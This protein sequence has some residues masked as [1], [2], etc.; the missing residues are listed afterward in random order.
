MERDPVAELREKIAKD[1]SALAR[2]FLGNWQA[3][4]LRADSVP[5]NMGAVESY[6]A[7]IALDPNN[8]PALA[9]LRRITQ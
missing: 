6:R 3:L 4:H 1:D 9:N 7:A 5:E 8:A 2:T